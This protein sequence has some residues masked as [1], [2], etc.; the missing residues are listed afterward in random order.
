MSSITFSGLSSGLDTD[1]IVKELMNIEKRPIT[2]LQGDKEWMN[3]RLK[4]FTSFDTKLNSFLSKIEKLDSSEDIRS[5]KATLS[6]EEFLSVSSSSEAN[7]GRYDIEVVDLAQVEKSV[8]QGY[9][10]QT[11]SE[12]GTGTLSISVGSEAPVE[13][14]IDETNNSLEGIKEA[15]NQAEAGVTATVIN[16]GTANP[17]R[18]V[19]T[20]EDTAD[21]FTLDSSGLS[22]GTYANPSL[23]ETQSAQQAHIRVDNIDIYSDSNTVSGAIEGVTLDLLKSEAGTTTSLEV[24]LDKASIQ[25]LIDEFVSG[26]NEVVSFVSNQSQM[27]GSGGGV[28]S[29]DS[30][31]NV[32]KRRLQNLLTT[33]LDN[34]GTFTALSELGLE[35]QRD[36]SLSVDSTTLGEAIENDLDSVEKLLA[37]EDDSQGIAVQFQNYLED[38][39][40]SRDGFLAGRETSI[41]NNI[42]RIETDIERMQDRLAKREETLRAQFM[43]MEQMMSQ[44]NAQQDFLTQQMDSISKIGSKD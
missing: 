25:G 8:T 18:L 16:D 26:Y 13:V 5:K 21:G 30:G 3:N 14:S 34:S 32:V 22:G 36:G 4:A 37:G 9:A 19:L 41:Q 2:R 39:T 29:G 38:I 44:L 42:S 12:F 1:N 6:S 15:I 23:T 11:A 7:A 35:T 24:D 33:R 10:D 17:Y 31:L 43:A 28:L 40:D 27:E 20:G